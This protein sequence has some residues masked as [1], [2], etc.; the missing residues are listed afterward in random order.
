[1]S[2]PAPSPSW[3]VIFV[4]GGPGAG[5]GTQCDQLAKDY[6]ACHLSIG[7][8]MRAETLNPASPVGPATMAVGMLKTA[9]EKRYR[10]KGATAFIIDGNWAER[11]L[12]RG[13]TS[14]RVDD[15]AVTI[16][17]RFNVFNEMT[18]PVIEYYMGQNKVVQIDASKD[19]SVVYQD[20]QTGLASILM[21]LDGKVG[22]L[23]LGNI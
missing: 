22:D 9:V 10:E 18:V 6:P 16:P 2:Q 1:M 11:L 21:T 17:K 14:G 19:Q 3:T 5:K 12:C 15:T 13:A 8:T 20:V 7:D 4:L 23:D